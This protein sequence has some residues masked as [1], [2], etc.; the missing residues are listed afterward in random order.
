MLLKRC[1][2]ITFLSVFFT[3][4]GKAQSDT[5]TPVEGY[6]NFAYNFH[7]SYG[8]IGVSHNYYPDSTLF[9]KNDELF[10]VFG[11]GV[12]LLFDR[13][14]LEVSF[15][16]LYRYQG[17]NNLIKD[18]LLTSYYISGGYNLFPEWLKKRWDIRFGLGINPGLPIYNTR[19]YRFYEPARV[20]FANR[21]ETQ[22]A[23]K[24][25]RQNPKLHL[26]P[27]IRLGMMWTYVKTQEHPNGVKFFPRWPVNYYLSFVLHFGGKERNE[28]NPGIEHLYKEF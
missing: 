27:S 22:L 4:L 10:Q 26:N 21:L 3:F 6:K 14:D 8:T 16:T 19:G 15:R 9:W 13:W 1:I 24:V 11:I 5:L 12:G 28:M 2:I 23:F 20:Y 7:L 18:A 17:F 25:L